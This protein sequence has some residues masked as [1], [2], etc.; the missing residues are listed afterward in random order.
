M[1][2]PPALMAASPAAVAALSAAPPAAAL[3]AAPAAEV[4]A[5]LPGMVLLLGT[6]GIHGSLMNDIK[7]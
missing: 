6:W 5:F 3:A 4:K 1:P 2:V 7:I